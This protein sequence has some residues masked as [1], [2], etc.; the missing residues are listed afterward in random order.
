MIG[1]FFPLTCMSDNW[2]ML[3]ANEDGIPKQRIR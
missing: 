2:D 1:I 3:R